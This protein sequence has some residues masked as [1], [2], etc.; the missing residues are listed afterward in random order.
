M[1]QSDR[2]FCLIRSRIDFLRVNCTPLARVWVQSNKF[3][4]AVTQLEIMRVSYHPSGWLGLGDGVRNGVD[5]E[6]SR[7]Q[8]KSDLKPHDGSFFPAFLS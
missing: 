8:G 4:S 6:H 2:G 5:G 1:V 3:K 7:S